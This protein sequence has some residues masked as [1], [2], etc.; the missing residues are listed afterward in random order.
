MKHSILLAT[1]WLTVKTSV[2]F[3]LKELNVFLPS[4]NQLLKTTLFLY[5]PRP[6]LWKQPEINLTNLQASFV[7]S[8]TVSLAQYNYRHAVAATRNY[9]WLGHFRERRRS[10]RTESERAASPC[11]YPGEQ[12]AILRLQQDPPRSTRGTRAHGEARWPAQDPPRPPRQERGRRRGL[13]RPATAGGSLPRLRR[14]PRLAWAH[15]VWSPPWPHLRGE[16]RLSWGRGDRDRDRHRL[17]SSRPGRP[18][19]TATRQGT[20]HRRLRALP[21]YGR[22]SLPAGRTACRVM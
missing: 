1:R 9:F 17:P 7:S 10:D 2:S 22:T 16:K 18:R 6:F 13:L 11:P 20:T 14:R 8:P 19:P 15:S 3:H 5:V 12:S 4:L 21:G